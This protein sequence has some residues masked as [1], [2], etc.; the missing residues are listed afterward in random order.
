MCPKDVND[1]LEKGLYGSPQIKPEEKA[2]YL[3]TFRERIFLAATLEELRDTSHFPLIKKAI[4]A[5]PGHQLLL[6]DSLDS[7]S[8]HTYMALAQKTGCP[9]KIITTTQQSNP[10]EIGLVYCTDQAVDVAD[11]SLA[12]LK[13]PDLKEAEP[14]NPRPSFFQKIWQKLTGR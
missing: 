3:G 14:A 13:G 1:Y 6:N 8:K 10:T 7:A 12:N 2:R 11:I 9:F 4:T 5:N